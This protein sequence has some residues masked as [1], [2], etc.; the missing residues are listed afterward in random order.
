MV[1]SDAMDGS[2]STWQK[3]RKN[4]AINRVIDWLEAEGKGAEAVNY[5]L[6]DWLISR[7]RYWG[8]PIPMMY[9][10][11]EIVPVADED[12]PVLLPEDV[13]FV[14][15]GRS[16]LTY[17]EPF[18]KVNETLRRETDTLDTFMCSS[19]YQLRYLSPDCDSCA[20]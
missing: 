20:L 4:P 5:R 7:Q 8:G 11:D 2:V 12:L 3:G 17:H 9:D 19:W 13:D 16:P 18:F 6:R 14:P 1:N 15:T 10:G